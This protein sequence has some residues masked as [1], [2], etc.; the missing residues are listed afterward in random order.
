MSA[1]S[2]ICLSGIQEFPFGPYPSHWARNWW[3]L[4]R[5]RTFRSRLTVWA[6]PPSMRRRS[7]GG[8]VEGR[9][10]IAFQTRDMEHRM[11]AA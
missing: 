4:P 9:Q 3:P 6:M 5:L 8:G 11:D 7:P 1:G 2:R 10:D